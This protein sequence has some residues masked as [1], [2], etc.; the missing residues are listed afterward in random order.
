MDYNELMNRCVQWIRDWFEVN[1]KGCK[2]IVGMSGGKDSTITAA[3]CVKALGEENVIGVLMPGAGQGLNDADNICN[4]LGI[5]SIVLPV[6]DLTTITDRFTPRLSELGGNW[7][8]QAQQNIPARLRMTL[9]YAVAQSFNG[10]VACTDNL[11]ENWLGYSTLFGDD[12]GS[13]AP[14]GLLTV[15][16]V[17]KIGDS[18]GIPKKWVY[19]LPDDG[20]P[21]SQPD[22][23]KLGITYKALDDYLRTGAIN[24]E[25]MKERIDSLHVSTQFKRDMIHIPT[26]DPEIPIAIA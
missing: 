23:Q 5:Q 2:A 13:F 18:L 24:D 1:G 6:S 22:E 25:V 7:S 19:K 9:L 14:L 15:S 4:H 21:N 10:R 8:E 11:S 3:L 20:L 26:F 12:A 17:R 16:E